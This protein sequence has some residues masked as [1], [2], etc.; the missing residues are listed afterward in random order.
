MLLSIRPRWSAAGTSGARNVSRSPAPVP[1]SSPTSNSFSPDRLDVPIHVAKLGLGPAGRDRGQLIAAAMELRQA[2]RLVEH[3]PQPEAVERRRAP[4]RIERRD[5]GEVAHVEH[6]G[7]RL[8]R[9]E[10]VRSRPLGHV[11]ATGP[12]RVPERGGVP[13]RVE[14]GGICSRVGVE[15]DEID[16]GVLGPRC[17]GR[18]ETPQVQL[19]VGDG[20]TERARLDD[21]QPDG[22]S[23]D[24]GHERH[25]AGDL[26]ADRPGRPAA[27]QSDA[28]EDDDRGRQHES[29]RG[30]RDRGDEPQSDGGRGERAQVP[31]LRESAVSAAARTIVATRV[32]MSGRIID[33]GWIPVPTQMWTTI[34]AGK[35]SA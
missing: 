31:R 15:Q 4:R 7:D 13:R 32:T 22:E 11:E 35:T 26:L 23:G 5:V 3:P 30:I 12:Q 2:A 25:A 6:R 20:L 19:D 17:G 8:R 16:V 9:L 28:D 18:A 1:R 24:R 21:L 10:I 33:A 34:A 14:R 29:D 27:G